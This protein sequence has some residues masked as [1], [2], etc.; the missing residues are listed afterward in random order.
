[1]AFYSVCRNLFG[2]TLCVCVYVCVVTKSQNH[3]T[4]NR[5]TMQL[6]QQATSNKRIKIIKEENFLK[7][8]TFTNWL[9][10]VIESPNW[11]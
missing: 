2:V 4:A 10:N 6:W 7:R 11:S 1:M 8:L 9:A 3:L 5:Q